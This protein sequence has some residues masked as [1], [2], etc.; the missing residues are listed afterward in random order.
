MNAVIFHSHSIICLGVTLE[1]LDEI[2]KRNLSLIG[3]LPGINKL[4]TP[5]FNK[6]QQG[7]A[8]VRAVV[9]QI[10][11]NRR[12]GLSHSLGEGSRGITQDV[13]CFAD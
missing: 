1:T 3:L 6:I 9:L 12:L 5:G 11:S 10:I 13:Q 2:Q 4:P 8:D 7:V